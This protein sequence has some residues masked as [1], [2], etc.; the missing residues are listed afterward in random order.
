MKVTMENRYS[1]NETII[2]QIKNGT[3]SKGSRVRILFPSGNSMCVRVHGYDPDRGVML[4]CS[5][6]WD[7][8]ISEEFQLS[9]VMVELVELER[10]AVG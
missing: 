7:N 8:S 5:M 2:R 1:Y 3:I 4:G 6:G 9:E 10:E